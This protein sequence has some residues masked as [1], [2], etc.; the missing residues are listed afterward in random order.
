MPAAA[1]LAEAG[2]GEASA[3]AAV[4]EEA[5]PDA[6]CGRAVVG[7]A[8]GGPAGRCGAD[9]GTLGSARLGGPLEPRLLCPS[10]DASGATW[11]RSSSSSLAE[12]MLRSECSSLSLSL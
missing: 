3:E 4:E 8:G 2:D 6:L 1:A 11:S 9:S 5:L 10:W 7:R 12:S